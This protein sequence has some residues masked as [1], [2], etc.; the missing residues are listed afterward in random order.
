MRKSLN[1]GDLDAVYRRRSLRE[2]HARLH[3]GLQPYPWQ[4]KLVLQPLTNEDRREAIM[5]SLRFQN[6]SAA[7]SDAIRSMGYGSLG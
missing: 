4:G 5:T 3:L 2:V 6:A 1:P 7:A